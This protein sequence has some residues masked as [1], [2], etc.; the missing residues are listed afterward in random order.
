MENTYLPDHYSLPS[1]IGLIHRS[2][3]VSPCRLSILLIFFPTYRNP[4]LTLSHMQMQSSIGQEP[5][6]MQSTSTSHQCCMVCALRML[7]GPHWSAVRGCCRVAWVTSLSAPATSVGPLSSRDAGTL[8]RPPPQIAA[9]NQ[10]RR[11]AAAK[12]PAKV[13]Q[14]Q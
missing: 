4:L 5:C 2:P 11:S 10:K 7:Q 3:C 9:G 14:Q 1:Y 12:V 6:A 13:Q 8:C